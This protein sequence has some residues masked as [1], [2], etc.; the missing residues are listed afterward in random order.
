MREIDFVR[1]PN[2]EPESYIFLRDA[3]SEV[4]PPYRLG[5]FKVLLSSRLGLSDLGP[6]LVRVLGGKTTSELAKRVGELA[7]AKLEEDNADRVAQNAQRW[8]ERALNRITN[9]GEW[10][11]PGS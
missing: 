3:A 8:A 2:K 4:I 10:I 6:E 1:I 11:N 9:Q 7:S 5:T